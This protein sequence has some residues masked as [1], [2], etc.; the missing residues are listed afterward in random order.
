M[1]Y[2]KVQ[3]GWK[4][5][6]RPVRGMCRNR[7]SGRT[8]LL[9]IQRHCTTKRCRKCSFRPDHATFSAARFHTLSSLI[10]ARC[11][12]TS[13]HSP[14]AALSHKHPYRRRLYAVQL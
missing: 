8:L 3:R 1:R 14:H 5:C 11:D 6:S 7:A 10:Q 13:P 9:A 12:L 4:R 2:D